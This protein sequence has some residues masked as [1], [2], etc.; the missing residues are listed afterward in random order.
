MQIYLSGGIEYAPDHGKAWRAAITPALRCSSGKAVWQAFC[1][2]GPVAAGA[3]SQQR[4]PSRTRSRRHSREEARLPSLPPAPEHVPIS[5]QNA[6]LCLTT[7]KNCYLAATCHFPSEKK[8]MFLGS[9]RAIMDCVHGIIE[10][11]DSI[12]RILNSR[13]IQRLRFIHQTGVSY[14]VYPNLEHS[15]FSHALGT[16]SVAT[17]VFRHLRS[18]ASDL[19]EMSPSR[20]DVDLERAF[21]IAALCHDLGH[22]AFSHALER[23]LLPKGITSHED[24]TLAL[25]RDGSD[26]A[27]QIRQT[28]CDLEQVVQLLEGTHWVSG[29]CK[30]LSGPIDCDRW[31]YLIRDSKLAGVRYGVFDLN[32]MVHSVSLQSDATKR[33]SLVIDAKRSLVALKQCLAARASMYQQVYLH[34]TVRGAGRVLRAI[35]ERA[36][37]S[38]RSSRFVSHDDATEPFK[39]LFASGELSLGDFLQTDDVEVLALLKSWERASKDPVLKYLSG[40]LLN[41]RLFREVRSWQGEVPKHEI[42]AARNAVTGAF[43]RQNIAEFKDIT[44]PELEQALDYLVLTD[45]SDFAFDGKIEGIFFDVGEEFPVSLAELKDR[46]FSS[47]LEAVTFQRHRL[48]VPREAAGAVETALESAS[49]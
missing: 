22:T 16:Y 36:S 48:Y 14:L 20:L 24:C 34:P 13:E 40:C 7:L 2:T 10:V 28:D 18:F 32:W 25:L 1:R 17:R 8:S 41:R 46:G 4:R 30:L 31:D 19:T 26:V 33:M 45:S 9:N 27:H 47:P 49:A 12:R 3:L 5:E 39:K 35:F 6:N 21:A 23:V 29:L 42:A 15:R 37:D 43:Q 44:E 38:G 11:D